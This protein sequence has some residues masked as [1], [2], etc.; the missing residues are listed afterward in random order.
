MIISPIKFMELNEVYEESYMIYLD[1][2]EYLLMS[3]E[4]RDYH[5]VCK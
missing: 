4:P 2:K 3:K 1:P 5:K